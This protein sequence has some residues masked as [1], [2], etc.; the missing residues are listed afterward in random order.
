MPVRVER[1]LRRGRPP[2]GSGEDQPRA[3][4]QLGCIAGSLRLLTITRT[5]N[6]RLHADGM[7]SEMVGPATPGRGSGQKTDAKKNPA[8]GGVGQST[9]VR[10]ATPETNRRRGAH[11]ESCAKIL[12]I[13]PTLAM[14]P[15][16]EISGHLP[17]LRDTLSNATVKVA[18]PDRRRSCPGHSFRLPFGRRRHAL[19][20]CRRLV[21]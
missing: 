11:G 17:R 6:F 13:Q 12:S 7:P 18:A 14:P 15:S 1:S 21:R 4:A 3:Y 2:F 16:P 8:R 19:A 20:C 5:A 9:S 10:Y